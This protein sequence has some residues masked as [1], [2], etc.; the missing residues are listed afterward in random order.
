MSLAV[1]TYRPKDAIFPVA[2]TVIYG[3]SEAILI[4][5]QFQAS[6]AGEL[7]Q[8]IRDLGRTLTTVFITHHDPD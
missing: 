1:K 6:R 2:S 7:V 3:K 4:D 8:M 5:A